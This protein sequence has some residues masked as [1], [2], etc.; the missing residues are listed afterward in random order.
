M[1]GPG[2]VLPS[3]RGEKVHR[4]PSRAG[5]HPRRGC[6]HCIIALVTGCSVDLSLQQGSCVQVG[7]WGA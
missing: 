6:S 7:A 4:S 3:V 1:S 2:A 5:P